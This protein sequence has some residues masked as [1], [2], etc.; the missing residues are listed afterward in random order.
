MP[1]KKN[2]EIFFAK[3]IKNLVYPPT[4]FYFAQSLG[5]KFLVRGREDRK[6]NYEAKQ[7]VGLQFFDENAFYPAKAILPQFAAFGT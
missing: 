4:G 1:K 2:N 7:A 3:I 5:G 6:R